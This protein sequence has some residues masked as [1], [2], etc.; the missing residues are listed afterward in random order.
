MDATSIATINRLPKNERR[1]ILIQVIPHELF[2][3]FHFPQDLIDQ[4]GN[5]L[6]T[7]RG[8]TES[9]DLEI[10]LFHEYRF[11]DP[12]LY[13][14]LTDTMNGQIHVLLYIMNDPQSPRFDVDKMPDGTPT[15]FGT[16]CR[17][18]EAELAAMQAGLMPGQ[19]RS[20]LSLLAEAT[21]AFEIFV[22][23]L[24]HSIYFV[25]PLYYHNALIFERYGFAYQAGR[26]RMKRIHEG[27]SEDGELSR[28]L[29]NSPFRLK[30]A[31]NS[32]RLRSWAIH[33]GI[34]GEPYDYVT[35][36]KSI[37][38]PANEN[39]TPNIPW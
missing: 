12:I 10:S 13:G 29:C 34:L 25:D 37:D 35:M 11:P 30:E 19:I 18:T 20:G 4:D 5:D 9:T 15:R 22:K 8:S 16:L 28:K 23:S 1:D 6:L 27:F 3:L 21:A 33:D 24:G 7:I 14:H 39:T 26:Q 36:Y 17:N 2:D 38:K 31:Q 32:I